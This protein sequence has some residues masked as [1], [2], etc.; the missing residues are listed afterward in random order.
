ML[1]GAVTSA[2]VLIGSTGRL[3]MGEPSGREEKSMGIQPVPSV[4]ARLALET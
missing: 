2:M 4:L 3:E 1:V